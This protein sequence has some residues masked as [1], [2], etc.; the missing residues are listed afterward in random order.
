MKDVLFGHSPHIIALR[1]MMCDDQVVFSNFAA[2]FSARLALRG[3]ATS[4][5]D[6]VLKVRGEYKL[7]L[8][9]LMLGIE[10]FL[11]TFPFIGFYKLK[12]TD[13]ALAT[14]LSVPAMAAVVSDRSSMV[15]MSRRDSSLTPRPH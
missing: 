1:I 2:L 14:V 11:S 4:V 10:L 7:A 9:G 12:V 13:A 8:F 15:T 3:G 5:E 6:T